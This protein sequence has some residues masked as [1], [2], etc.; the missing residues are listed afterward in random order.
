MQ[1]SSFPCVNNSTSSVAY[2]HTSEAIGA[3]F[4]FN[5][6]NKKGVAF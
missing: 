1:E 5:K 3:N 6:E 4:L 2:I